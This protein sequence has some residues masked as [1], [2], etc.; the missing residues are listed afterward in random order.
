MQFQA[1]QA[2]QSG[3]KPNQIYTFLLASEN[4]ANMC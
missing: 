2:I 1:S 4:I 3:K